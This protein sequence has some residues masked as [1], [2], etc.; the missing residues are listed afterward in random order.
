MA[1][2]DVVDWQIMALAYPHG[3]QSTAITTDTFDFILEYQAFD[4][5]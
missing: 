5:C 4:E 1:K 2:V 3:Q